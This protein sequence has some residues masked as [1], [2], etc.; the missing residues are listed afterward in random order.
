MSAATLPA[1][2]ATGLSQAARGGQDQIERQSGPEADDGARLGPVEQGGGDREQP[3]E[4]GVGA[5]D[6]QRDHHGLLHHQHD[7]DHQRRPEHG[8]GG[9]AGG[10]HWTTST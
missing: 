4:V 7:E 10:T 1:S 2:A 9:H 3:Q 5:A 8:A 6:A